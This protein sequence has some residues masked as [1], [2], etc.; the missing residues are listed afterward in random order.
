MLEI[1]CDGNND[2]CEYAKRVQ[3]LKATED[4]ILSYKHVFGELCV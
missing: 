3:W 1:I 4:N 2:I